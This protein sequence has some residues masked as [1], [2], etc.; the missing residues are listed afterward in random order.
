MISCR[1]LM[2]VPWPLDW[3]CVSAQRLLKTCFSVESFPEWTSSWESQ[4]EVLE[5]FDMFKAASAA[6]LSCG[7][8]AQKKQDRE[9]VVESPIYSPFIIGSWQWQSL[10]T[11]RSLRKSWHLT[12]K[13]TI[14]LM[15]IAEQNCFL[16]KSWK[17]LSIPCLTLLDLLDLL[18]WLFQHSLPW[19]VLS[20][21]LKCSQTF[22]RE[23]SCTCPIPGASKQDFGPWES[24]HETKA[25]K[26]LCFCKQKEGAPWFT[27]LPATQLWRSM[28]SPQEP[29]R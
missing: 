6:I 19:A 24:L 13:E 1:K 26:A 29:I 20:R 7:K 22:H 16:Q 18:G 21:H 3:L 11:P 12:D 14:S 5:E 27:G 8:F 2:E 28:L 9:S 23:E 25:L 10:S 15:H 4:N 17:I